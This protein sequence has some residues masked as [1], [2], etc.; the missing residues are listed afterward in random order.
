M[1][2]AMEVRIALILTVAP[3]QIAARPST[4]LAPAATVAAKL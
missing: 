2:T 4:H 1:K 3:I